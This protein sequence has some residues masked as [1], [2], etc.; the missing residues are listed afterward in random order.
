MASGR[1]QREMLDIAPVRSRWRIGHLFEP[2]FATVRV[3]AD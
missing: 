1:H 2:S 3:A